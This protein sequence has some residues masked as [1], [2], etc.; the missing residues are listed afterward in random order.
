MKT[1]EP[2]SFMSRPFLRSLVTSALLVGAATSAVALPQEVL[3]DSDHKKLGK[4][5]GAYFEATTEE[6]GIAEALEDVKESLDKLTKKTKGADPLS[7]VEDLE[8]AVF[9]AND[10]GK[11][12]VRKGKGKID[13]WP[14]EHGY[15]GE[16]PV[17][18]R[19]PKAYNGSKGIYTLILSLPDEGQSAADHLQQDWT[20]TDLLANSVL[21]SFDMPSDTTLWDQIGEPGN[22]GGLGMVMATFGQLNKTFAV[23]MDRVFLAGRGAAVPAAINIAAQYPHVFA[24][25]VGRAGDAAADADASNFINT[26]TFFAGAGSG[27]TS[28]QE[29]A[30]PLGV[31]NCTISADASEDDIWGW[32]QET[33]RDPMPSRVLFKPTSRVGSTSFWLQAQG[34]EENTSSVEAVADRETNTITITAEN[35][36]TVNLFFSDLLVDMDKPIK[37][38]TNGTVHEDLIPRNFQ[39]MLTNAYNNGDTG[40]IFTANHTY[41]IPEGG[42]G[43]R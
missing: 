17:V 14:L 40:R 36:A 12:K 13:P 22:A 20:N 37:V 6:K 32:M 5:I 24:G 11:K 3:K 33:R 27:A 10:Y 42:D 9:Y 29:S 43:T 8:R 2:N 4:L 21:V 39:T 25:V 16:L 18:L 26:A 7:C 34:F 19:A 30:K 15:F 41:N 1:L 23:D 38:I 35:V 31:E 28:F